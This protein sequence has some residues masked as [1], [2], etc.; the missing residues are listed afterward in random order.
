MLE[1]MDNQESGGRD[2]ECAFLLLIHDDPEHAE[3]ICRQ[4]RR[5]SV[6][7]HVDAKSVE[8][9]IERLAALSNVT[10]IP[11]R[12]AVYWAGFAM[13]E[14]TLALLRAALASGKAF[15]RFVLMSGSCYPIKPIERLEQLFESEPE[16]EFI[17]LVAIPPAGHLRKLIGRRWCMEPWL[18]WRLL[19]ITPPIM[20]STEKMVRRI[21]NK[22]ASRIPRRLEVEIVGMQ[23]Y[24]GS[25][26]WALTRDC[27]VYILSFVEKHPEVTR[28]YRSV[29]APDEHFF[30]TIVGNSPFGSRAIAGKEGLDELSLYDAPLHFVFYR[31]ERNATNDLEDFMRI[32][33][34]PKYFARKFRSKANSETLDRIDRELLG[35]MQS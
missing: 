24:F 15:N 21:Y 22:V 19:A 4:L 23:P 16:K 13:V 20:A 29:W 25:Q 17:N 12:K 7:V 35:P 10:I 14:A 26:W 27:V 32:R 9:P 6:F 18:P 33:E 11:E 28:A 5:Y 1:N 30:Q 2:Q 3:R 34:S 31:L 8:F